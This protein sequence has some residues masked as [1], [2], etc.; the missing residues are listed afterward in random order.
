MRIIDL[1]SMPSGAALLPVV[2]AIAKATILF[3]T[4]GLLS[5]V[6]RRGSAAVRH[7][8]WTLALLSALVLPVL[9]IA[10]P[11][12][13]VGMIQ[14]PAASSEPRVVNE[15]LPAAPVTVRLKADTTS[16]GSKDAGRV[17]LQADQP[18]DQPPAASRQPL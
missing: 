18:A 3:A 14:L 5:V 10:L 7:L 12:W 9:S 15:S 13:Q 6:L 1:L 11:K 2:D 4:A 8:I 16:A 17:R